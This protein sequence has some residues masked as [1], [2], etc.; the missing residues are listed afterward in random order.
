M[1]LREI[2]LVIG[3][4]AALALVV[5]GVN[6]LLGGGAAL[7]AAGVGVAALTLLFLAEVA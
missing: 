1:S 3:M 2:L 6:V 4:L 7:I 5:A